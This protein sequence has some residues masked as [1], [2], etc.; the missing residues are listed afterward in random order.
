MRRAMLVLDSNQM[1]QGVPRGGLARGALLLLVWIPIALL[2]AR[3]LV[4]LQQA[5]EQLA[6]RRAPPAALVACR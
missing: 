5:A 2:V 1:F 4:P 3:E 6:A